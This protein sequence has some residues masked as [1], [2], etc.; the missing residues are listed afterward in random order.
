MILTANSVEMLIKNMRP[1]KSLGLFIDVDHSNQY[2]IKHFT[3]M[4]EVNSEV[5]WSE[6]LSVTPK[7][8]VPELKTKGNQNNFD[9]VIFNNVSLANIELVKIFGYLHQIVA[10]N[11]RY[12]II[13][14]H[15]RTQNFVYKF[16]KIFQCDRLGN[17]SSNFDSTILASIIK[18]SNLEAVK[19]GWIK[20]KKTKGS[21]NYQVLK[22]VYP[23]TREETIS[24]I[25][26]CRNERQNISRIING[27][28]QL[29]FKHELIF[30]EGNSTDGTFQE[31]VEQAAQYPKN[32]ISYKTQSG[33]GKYNAVLEGLEA[34]VGSYIV[35]YDADMT[36]LPEDIERLINYLNNSNADFINATRMIYPMEAN[37]MQKL[38]Y[39]ANVCFAFI[40]SKILNTRLT[41]TLCGTKCFTREYGSMLLRIREQRP[42]KDPFGDFEILARAVQ[43]NQ[44][45]EEMPVCY[46]AR[47]H[48]VTQIS[49][50][51]DGWKL[52][53]LVLRLVKIR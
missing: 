38:N 39:L 5:A 20:I 4:P 18:G 53:V 21:R 13:S 40:L 47:K 42:L 32:K 16:K 26:P 2:L 10:T 48:G 30:V 34:A 44:K 28:T 23:K 41:D 27:L 11:S 50:F 19:S 37:A 43:L 25:I 8:L 29:N 36:V 9:L 35:I 14:K 3:F 49:R 15:N 22:P 52:F 6:E 12:V 31:I 1:T 24:F 33:S 17:A 45:I 51:S 46:K 7:T